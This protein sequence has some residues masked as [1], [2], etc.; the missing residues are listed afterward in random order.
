M[1]QVNVRFKDV[2]QVRR[3]VNVID[4]FDTSFDLGSGQRV[5]DAKSLL[6]VMGLDFS[7]PLR[8]RYHSNDDRIA[9]EIAPFLA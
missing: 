9:E 4:K 8:L 5:V 7:E 1:Q 3:F 2:E 6:G